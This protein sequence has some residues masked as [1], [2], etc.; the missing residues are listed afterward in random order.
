MTN[1]ADQDRERNQREQELREQKWFAMRMNIKTQAGMLRQYQMEERERGYKIQTLEFKSPQYL[2]KNFIS[3]NSPIRVVHVPGKKL[4]HMQ[5]RNSINTALENLVFLTK[6]VFLFSAR[7][8][9]RGFAMI[10]SPPQARLAGLYSA[11]LAA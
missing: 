5:G 10:M 6:S 8:A 9:E 3:G 1:Y 2:L 7:L 11:S 4:R